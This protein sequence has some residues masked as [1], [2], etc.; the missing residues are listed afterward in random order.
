MRLHR[1]HSS[2]K[3]GVNGVDAANDATLADLS[4]KCVVIA[5]V[6]QENSTSRAR[7]DVVLLLVLRVGISSCC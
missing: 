4:E 3:Q 2:I 7:L 6:S 5:G 1:F